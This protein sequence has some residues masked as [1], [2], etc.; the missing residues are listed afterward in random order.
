[1]N[2]QKVKFKTKF[3]N[4]L[5]KNSYSLVV[6]GCAMVLAVALVVTATVSRNMLNEGMG[7]LDPSVDTFVP[8][9]DIQ[10]S[11]T[12][13]IVFG[14]PVKDYTLG[15]TF[16]N[17]SLVYNS[18]LNEY[19]THLGI[20]FIVKDGTN[21]VASF[22]GVVESVNFEN[23]TG[24]TIII[25][26]GDGLKTSYGSLSSDVKVQVGQNVKTGE[27]IGVASNSAGGEQNLGSHVHY[28]VFENGEPI[29]PMMYLEQK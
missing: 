3:K 9:E 15:N 29:N 16:T 26:H 25:N 21:V 19:T 1:M 24:T 7:N 5:M 11:S 4:F 27:V 14:Y 28:E 2:Q 8:E 13:P 22:D 6:I 18:T 20:D 12:A 23:L 10:A 17:E